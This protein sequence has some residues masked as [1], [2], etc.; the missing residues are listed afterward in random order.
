MDEAGVSLMSI[1]AIY[2]KYLIYIVCIILRMI[3]KT[4]MKYKLKILF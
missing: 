4:I 1:S 3:S 2:D